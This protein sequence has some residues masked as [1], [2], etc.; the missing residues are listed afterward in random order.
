LAAAMV[1]GY[2][3]ERPLTPED[4]AA[5]HGETL[6]A[7]LRFATTRITDYAMRAPPG[8]KPTRDYR[9]FLARF[10]AVRRLGPSGWRAFL[11]VA[12]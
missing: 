3:S 10:E 4:L 2:Q 5:L 7:A 1:A 12:S 8:A 6:L 9:R 11:G